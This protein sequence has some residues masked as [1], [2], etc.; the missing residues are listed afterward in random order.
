VGLGVGAAL[1]GTV[2][3]PGYGPYPDWDGQV[4]ADWEAHVI[5]AAAEALLP[6]A[7]DGK[8][9]LEVPANVDRYL[10]HLPGSLQR[11]VHAALVAVEHGTTPLSGRWSRMSALPVEERAAWLSELAAAGGLRRQLYRGIRDLCMVGFYQQPE[12]WTA[13]GYG[14]PSVSGPRLPSPYDALAAPAGIS[15][16]GWGPA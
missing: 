10:V 5:H 7:T 8:R 16:R 3:V 12:T 13:L 14:G 11:E 15:P 2:R 9:Y 1:A 4:L 6:P